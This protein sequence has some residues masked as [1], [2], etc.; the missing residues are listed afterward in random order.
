VKLVQSGTEG[1]TMETD[2]NISPLIETVVE[3]GRLVIRLQRGVGS[4]STNTLRLTVNT[5]NIE[6]L[7]VNGSGNISADK[8]KTTQL[9]C[10]I[11]GSGDLR[12]GELDT[13]KL[14]VSIAGSGDFLASGHAELLEGSIAGS[15][16]L[17]AQSLLANAVVLSI[18]GS[19]DAAV[20]AVKTL[21]VRIAGSGDVNYFG[22]AVLDQ[23][24]AGS[25]S[26]RHLGGSPVKQKP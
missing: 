13:S 6:Q 12:I 9:K 26:V 4:I 24:I 15:G 3:H 16:D 19:G 14:S 5:R 18:A 2:D 17:N 7:D 23:S 11:L 10:N 21:K 25:G 8:L 22:D 1:L 20:W